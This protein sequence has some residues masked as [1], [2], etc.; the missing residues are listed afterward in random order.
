MSD[1]DLH[2]PR[3]EEERYRIYTYKAGDPSGSILCTAGT[4]EA[5][6]LALVTMHDERE[7]PPGTA[8]GV[9]DA[10]NRKWII[11][12]WEVPDA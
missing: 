11:N 4:P 3:S 10:V 12:P 8:V 7:F 1:N 6:G 9:L 5:L 2:Y